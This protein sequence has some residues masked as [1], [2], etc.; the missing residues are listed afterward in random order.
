[1]PEFLKGWGSLIIAAI[2]LVQ[3]WVISIFKKFFRRKRIEIYE[4]GM[5]EIGLSAFGPTIALLGSLNALHGDAIVRDMTLK[6]VRLKDK[7]EHDFSWAFFRPLKFVATGADP[8]LQFC[9]TFVAPSTS[10][11]H[12]NIIFLDRDLID[13][14]R[15]LADKLRERWN[16]FLKAKG[17]LADVDTAAN[18]DLV[19]ARIEQIKPH[20]YQD[21]AKT[22]EHVNTYT[23]LQQM[24][25]WHPGQYSL[26]LKIVTVHPDNKFIK[27]WAFRLTE[28]DSKLIKLNLMNVLQEICGVTQFPY[29]FAYVKYESVPNA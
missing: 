24:F 3:P 21:F 23:A 11:Y 9:S 12:F 4:T 6:V 22:S 15:P 7:A 10:P 29:N 19:K 27:K 17:Q 1:M 14:A 20:A 13:E 25:Y 8:S 26:Q 2:A 28:D 16:E 5:I 18:V